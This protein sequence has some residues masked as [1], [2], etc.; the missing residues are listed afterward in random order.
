MDVNPTIYDTFNSRLYVLRTH[1]TELEQLLAGYQQAE[2]ALRESEER[3]RLLVEQVQDYAIFMLDP[4][5]RVVSWNAG[6]ERIKGYTAKEIIG[7]HFSRFYPPDA[8]AIGKPEQELVAARADGRVEDEDWR[9]RK[10]GSLFWANVVITTLYD[11]RGEL[12]G[13]AK[14]TRDLT[15]RKR[16]EDEREQLLQRERQARVEAERL[17]GFIQRLQVLTD[18]ALAHLALDDLLRVLLDRLSELLAADTVAIL[19]LADRGDVLAVRAAKGLEEEISR[20]VRIPFGAGIAGRIA[21]ERRP[22]VVTEIDPTTVLSPVLREKGVRSLLGVPLLVEGRVIGVVHV[23]TLTRRV[24]TDED[25]HLLQLAADRMSLAIE[26]ARLFADEQVTRRKAEEALHL[27]E[28]FLNLASH[29]LKTPLTTLMGNLELIERR[30]SKAAQLL[31]RDERLLRVSIDQA[32]RLNQLVDMMLD[33]SRIQQGRLTIDRKPIELVGLVR[34]IIEVL[35]PGLQQHSIELRTSEPYLAIEGDAL[36]LRQ[37]IENLLHN[38][39]TFSPNGGP[40]LIEVEQRGTDA[41]VVVQDQGIGI[42][43]DHLARIFEGFYTIGTNDHEHRVGM[44][45]GLFMVKEIVTLHGGMVDVHSEVGKGSVFTISLPL[46]GP[47]DPI[48]RATAG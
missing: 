17:A 10:D 43:R 6:A 20:G 27:R 21:A 4:D 7:E 5:G 42:P 24:F 9:V 3:F 30:T 34:E 25:V 29:E 35:R 14:V 23:G 8:L 13:F 16:A 44:G 37:I 45:I 22:V 26:H 19:L 47:H 40:L 41:C 31:Q 48:S 32:K 36:R 33:I 15:E 18:A 11:E 2:Q 39:I 28:Q 1:L 38:A 46:G 12:R